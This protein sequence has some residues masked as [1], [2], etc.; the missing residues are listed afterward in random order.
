MALKTD[1]NVG[2]SPSSS[3]DESDSDIQD[4]FGVDEGMEDQNNDDANDEENEEKDGSSDDSDQ[5][6]NED[7]SSEENEGDEEEN[8]GDESSNT[9]DD[10]AGIEKPDSSVLQK[11]VDAIE[12]EESD[13]DDD[14][15]N[16]IGGGDGEDEESDEEEDEEGNA[17][18]ADAMSK[19]LCMGKNTEKKVS[20]LSKAKKDNAPKK[21]T[22]EAGELKEGEVAEDT[23][24]N[25]KPESWAIM[26]AKKKEIDSHGRRKPDVLDR[27]NEKMLA[28]IATRGVVQLFNAVKEHQKSVKGQ[29]NTAGKSFRKRE[30]VYKNID[31]NKFLEVLTGKPSNPD[32]PPLKKAKEEVVK[33]E[34]KMEDDQPGG[35]NILRDDFMLGAKMRDWDKQ[36]DD[37]N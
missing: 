29:L 25:K 9:D 3:E 14:S 31:K 13:D 18:W 7:A 20:I 37:E 16:N 32:E 8:D 36:S 24:E 33:K 17:G 11:A 23:K 21:A 30:K 2:K 12:S 26:K 27:S 1:V 15:T 6:D 4:E 5:D 10:D 35:W 22:T 19:V 28:K 34:E